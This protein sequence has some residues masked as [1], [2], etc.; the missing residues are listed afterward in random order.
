MGVYLN[1]AGAKQMMPQQQG[2]LKDGRVLRKYRPAAWV[3]RPSHLKFMDP[4]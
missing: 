1:S 2:Q 4:R 3:D